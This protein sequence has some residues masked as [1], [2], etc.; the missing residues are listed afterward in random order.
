[1]RA[2]QR[3]CASCRWGPETSDAVV[4]D[5]L[6]VR[7]LFG[8]A[9]LG[10]GKLCPHQMDGSI[11]KKKMR[12]RIRSLI[13]FGPPIVGILF[14]L[15]ASWKLLKPRELIE[16]FAA[17]N[18]PSAIST[19]CVY[20]LALVEIYLAYGLCFAKNKRIAVM[21]GILCLAVF[22]LYLGYLASMAHPPKCGCGRLM[23]LFES[24]RKNAIFGIL[25]NF[26]LIGLLGAYLVMDGA[27]GTP[28]QL[29]WLVNTA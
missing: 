9:S 1:V 20:S 16:S 23:E 14:A 24:N 10:D 3:N 6:L 22:T 13:R 28:K 4:S 5:I 2:S 8:L 17:H 18:M 29:A 15:S 12:K 19:P 26:A 27:V 11:L 25:R 7:D 21:L